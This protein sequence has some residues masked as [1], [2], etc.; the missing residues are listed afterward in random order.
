[1]VKMLL[2]KSNGPFPEYKTPFN[3]GGFSYFSQVRGKKRLL[4]FK[5]KRKNKKKNLNWPNTSFYLNCTNLIG[6]KEQRK[7]RRKG[8]ERRN[9]KERKEKNII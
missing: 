9:N 2:F 8:K 3:F 5:Y 7:K 4:A 6:K 1:M